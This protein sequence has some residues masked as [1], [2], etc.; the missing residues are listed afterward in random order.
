MEAQ[1]IE[2]GILVQ[3]MATVAAMDIYVATTGDDDTGDGLVGNPYLTITRAYQDVPYTLRHLV[4]IHVAAGAY[5]DWPELIRNTYE[6]GGRLSID[7]TAAM[8]D[9]AV[10]PYTVGGGAP[11]KLGDSVAY[12]VP[13]VGGGLT[14]GAW[15]GLFLEWLDG[16]QAGHICAI[17]ENDATDVRIQGGWT[18]GGAGDK[19]KIVEPG[20]EVTLPAVTHAIEGDADGSEINVLALVGMKLIASTRVTIKAKC[21]TVTASILDL[22]V[23]TTD[24]TKL[25]A[26]YWGTITSFIDVPIFVTGWGAAGVVTDVGGGGAVSC[27]GNCELYGL[28]FIRSVDT[29]K[30][31]FRITACAIKS[32]ANYGID[33]YTGVATFTLANVYIEAVVTKGAIQ[34]SY[35]GALSI[36]GLYVQEGL[37]ALH[38]KR[39]C[40]ACT[41]AELGGVDANVTTALLLINGSSLVIAAAT[42]TLVGATGAGTAVRWSSGAADSAYPAAN[43]LVSDALGAQVVGY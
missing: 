8:A 4:H 32:V 1:L 19:F 16:A 25:D 29:L 5:T 23:V 9:K 15:D 39:M 35:C 20:V 17:I 42:C 7:G 22:E 27:K 37:A 24:D 26:S 3:S 21:L 12:D 18:V 34:A 10:G 13:V 30:S 40:G 38:I 14:P 41:I 43:L 33:A 28:T 6:T 11:V 31:N 36:G 2:K